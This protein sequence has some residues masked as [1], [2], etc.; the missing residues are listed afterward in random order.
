MCLVNNQRATKQRKVPQVLRGGGGVFMWIFRP[1]KGRRIWTCNFLLQPGL[2]NSENQLIFIIFHIAR[3]RFSITFLSNQSNDKK[4]I[5]YSV[6]YKCR[7]QT[8]H[9]PPVANNITSLR[10]DAN[11]GQC[12]QF[13]LLRDPP[14]CPFSFEILHQLWSLDTPLWFYLPAGA[15]CI[16]LPQVFSAA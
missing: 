15:S 3:S 13:C 11:C 6:Q 14:I 7:I 5:K 1:L 4:T 16:S 9:P 10:A 2:G 8:V 12:Q